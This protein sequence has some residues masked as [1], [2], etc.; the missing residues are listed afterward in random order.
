MGQIQTHSSELRHYFP[1]LG[2]TS[3]CAMKGWRGGNNEEDC[4]ST[5]PRAGRESGRFQHAQIDLS[6]LG[7]KWLGRRQK[8]SGA[9]EPRKWPPQGLLAPKTASFQGPGS[10]SWLD[11]MQK[12]IPE[13][14]GIEPGSPWAREKWDLLDVRPARETALMVDGWVRD[15]GERIAQRQH[16]P[17]LL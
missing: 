13:R 7:G 16:Q 12:S 2:F 3:S 15:S 11:H 6:G 9:L 1:S 5:L 4:I 8:P 10:N 14:W 17:L